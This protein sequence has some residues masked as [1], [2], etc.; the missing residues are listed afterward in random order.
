MTERNK[1]NKNSCKRTDTTSRKILYNMSIIL[2]LLCVFIML[3]TTNV[4]A[5]SSLKI[6]YNGK[7]VNYT[8]TQ[9]KV[10]YNNQSINLKNTPGIIINDTTLVSYQEVFANSVIKA[11]CSTTSTGSI[12]IKKGATTIKM[13]VGSKVA[14]VN[15]KKKT[16]DTAPLKVTYVDKK[17]TKVLVP[18][19]FV[20][21]SLGYSYTWNKTKK[22]AEIVGPLSLT[23]D[24]KKYTYSSTQGKVTINGTSINLGDMPGIIINNTALLRAKKVFADS[25]MKAKYEYNS[26][27]KT[28]ILTK[29]ENTIQMTMG[30]RIA[31]VNGKK[32]TMDTAAR[33]IRNNSTKK[34]YVM[35]PGH[36]VA[37]N[38]G[39]N[40]NWNSTTKTSVITTK[41]K[42]EVGNKPVSPV[43]KDNQ[44]FNYSVAKE[45]E[46]QYTKVKNISNGEIL[47]SNGNMVAVIESVTQGTVKDGY[48]EKYEIKSQTPFDGI[49][50]SYE[51]SNVISFQLSN[52]Y[53]KNYTYYFDNSK[54][55]SITSTYNSNNN[56]TNVTL[57]LSGESVSY[58]Y[59]LS[60]DKKTLTITVHYNYISEINAYSKDY[61]DYVTITG[62]SLPEKMISEDNNNI[63]IDLPYTINSIGALSEQISNGN[64]I[65]Q[66]TAV[67]TSNHST[68]ITISKKPDTEYYTSVSGTNLM[69]A[70]LNSSNNFD[71]KI[72]L[73]SNVTYSTVTTE[74]LYWN[75]KFTITIPGDQISYYNSNPIVNLSS[76]IKSID[77][78]LNSSGN[79]VIT[80]V[81]SSVLGYRLTDSG[82]SI[83]VDVGKPNEIYKNIVVLDPGHGGSYPGAVYSGVK[84]KDL[85]LKILYT[86]LKDYFNSSDIKVYYTRTNDTSLSTNL[87]EDLAARA[88]YASKLGA[89]L[90]ISLHMNAASAT[91]AKGTEV[92][93]STSNNKKMES[94]LTS[95]ILARE[96][97][98]NLS[99]TIGL[100][101]RGVKT[102][103]FVV[104]HKNTV[105]AVLI[106]LGFMTNSS[107]LEILTSTSYQKKVAKC[108]FDTIES[109]FTDYPTG[110]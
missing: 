20:T 89:D 94:G 106:E 43:N 32:Y 19:R 83:T 98:N 11:T 103:K 6:K 35:V 49:S 92:Y 24:N 48:S 99:S 109:I 80:F 86:Y 18:A 27:T 50:S 66:V 74:D 38:L 12:T 108:I 91:S 41:T 78:G 59:D 30:S 16:M 58:E 69:I 73:P 7:T 84:E 28:V 46:E 82:D 105:P 68:R 4:S 57:S 75:K 88:A 55:N 56:S 17:T 93:Y 22:T 101:N 45:F 53:S 72:M 13:T 96:L 70:L 87:S 79:T 60:K 9:A 3:P 63:Y 23:Y 64:G 25:S 34:T 100:K 47:S 5:S 52:T 10:T 51:N 29:G 1:N 33:T 85:T 39:Y 90:F 77:I 44:Y 42:P 8:G 102:A 2:L 37:T 76:Q 21:E 97:V 71:V 62:L 65:T 26:S 36:F 14:Y 54:V 107:D 31:Y 15:G 40:Y 61:T 67:S 95:D 110:R 81:G 104:V